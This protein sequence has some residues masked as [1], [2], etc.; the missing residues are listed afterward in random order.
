[1][2]YAPSKLMFDGVIEWATR[3]SQKWLHLGGGVNSKE[4]S[5]YRFK[6]GFSPI[7]NQ[8]TTLRI[9]HDQQRYNNLNYVALQEND[10]TEFDDK[11]YFPLY[12]QKKVKQ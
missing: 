11:D 3:S 4:D 9:I 5:L 7:K 8:F 12:R 10:Q 6:K 2:E 1:M